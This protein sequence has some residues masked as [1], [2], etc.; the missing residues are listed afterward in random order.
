MFALYIHGASWLDVVFIVV[1]VAA[2]AAHL[3][4]VVGLLASVVD[5]FFGGV[6]GYVFCKVTVSLCVQWC[7]SSGFIRACDPT[8]L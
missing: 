5:L 1:T 6:F 8:N 4:A 2:N 7:C 3:V